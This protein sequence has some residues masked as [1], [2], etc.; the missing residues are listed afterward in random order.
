MYK[1][2]IIM[3]ILIIQYNCSVGDEWGGHKGGSAGR[4]CDV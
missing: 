4:Y 1:K 3:W 2:W